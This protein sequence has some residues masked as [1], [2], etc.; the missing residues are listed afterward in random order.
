MTEALAF[1]SATE[2]AALV[3]T[4]ALSPV[5]LV[6]HCLERIA[7]HD[8]A[9]GAVATLDAE[10]AVATAREMAEQAGGEQTPAF[11]GVPLLVKDNA[12]T[13]GLRT[14]FATAALAE[15]VPPF[16]AEA[17][18][19][20]RRAGFVVLGKSSLPELGTAPHSESALLG[21]CRNPWDL[22]HS[23]GGSS[24]GG[25]AALAAGLVPVAHGTDGAGSLRIPAAT[26][27]LV[28]LKPTRGRIS[29]APLFGDLPPGLGLVTHGPLART[30]TDA[31]GLL[32]ALAG[33]AVG[34]PHWAPTPERSFA[35]E[36]ALA[37]PPLRIGVASEPPLGE[38][39]AEPLRAAQEAATALEELGHQ[40][41]P[42]RLPA[43]EELAAPFRT[44]WSAQVAAL[45]FDPATMEPFNQQLAAWG[46]VSA[47]EAL[48][49][50]TTLQAASRE[51][52]RACGEVD[53]VLSPTVTRPPLRV[54]EL[55]ALGPAEGF[56]MAERFVGL[57][58]VANMTGQPAIALPIGF[59]RAGARELPLGV[60]LL[61]RPA[62]EATLLRLA[63]QLEEVFAWQRLRPP[64]AAQAGPSA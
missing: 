13:E 21:A 25:A 58:P 15:F 37:P 14:T 51:I 49:A 33:Y 39:G 3:R 26:C 34:D 56:A 41:E 1:R 64:L 29:N 44:L 47:P 30:V 6:E 55:T 9:L 10:R 24:G 2:L 23:P 62:A 18:A 35:E 53:V 45:P 4:R 8:P 54:G 27:G 11:H 28:G 22:A 12:L 57:S 46:A 50:V 43:G 40:L 17:V 19:R 16:D 48:N 5:E 63:A 60:T 42:L 20:L 36:A 52:V 61:G 38:F 32:D 59:T 7:A 31:A